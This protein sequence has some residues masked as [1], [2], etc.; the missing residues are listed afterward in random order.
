MAGTVASLFC[1][2][3]CDTSQIIFFCSCPLVDNELLGL[4]TFS[5]SHALV[6]IDSLGPLVEAMVKFGDP[7]SF[8]KQ[9]LTLL[10]HLLLVFRLTPNNQHSRELVFLFASKPWLL[11]GSSSGLGAIFMLA[12]LEG[13]ANWVAWDD[14]PW[15]Q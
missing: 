7:F 15:Y 3:F 9:G 8:T 2:S 6:R 14:D 13:P 4:W 5:V 10:V 1:H 12:W 11:V